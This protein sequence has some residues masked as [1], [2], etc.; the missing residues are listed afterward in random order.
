[1]MFFG[2]LTPEA[3]ADGFS[4]TLS[5]SYPEPGEVFTATIGS[6]DFSAPQN[7]VTW[8]VN[9]HEASTDANT[10]T[11][12]LT[13][14]ESPMTLTA[15]VALA[16]GAVLERK[17]VVDP[18]RVDLIAEPN[19]T[20]PSFYRG[21]PLP[22]SGSSI[23]VAALVFKNGVRTTA[24]LSYAWRVNNV[25]QKGSAVSNDAITIRSNFE[26]TMRV[27]VDVLN[28]AEQKIAEDTIE[29]PIVEPEVVFYEKNPLR[30]LSLVALAD[31]FTLIGAETALRAETYFMDAALPAADVF[32]EWTQNSTALA[33]T[34]DPREISLQPGGKHGDTRIGYSIHNLRQLLQSAKGAITV[35][36]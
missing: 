31:P 30:G 16:S 2:M 34:D 3:N 15:R 12:T 32:S 20:V 8:F 13:V 35:R 23:R 27:S 36:F 4:I 25:T 33:A 5:P 22:S 24:G 26:K 9:G 14:P 7:S 11:L 28:A 10:D 6:R 21:H 18:Y 29:I 1:M 19:T 17:Y